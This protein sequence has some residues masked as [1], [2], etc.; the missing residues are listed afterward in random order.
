MGAYSD[1]QGVSLVR[2][3]VAKFISDRD[4]YPAS[5]RISSSP[6]VLLL[7]S[8]ISHSYSSQGRKT[9]S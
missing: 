2:E 8:D 3:E 9:V 7:V 6:M 5:L 4:G 1:S